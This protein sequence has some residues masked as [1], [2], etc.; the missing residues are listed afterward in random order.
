M[1]ISR[2]SNPKGEGLEKSHLREPPPPVGEN[3][4]G[5]AQKDPSRARE[6]GNGGI[7]LHGAEGE[8][9]A[10]GLRRK[11]GRK[12]KIKK[13][14]RISPNCRCLLMKEKCL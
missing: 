2:P 14:V 3:E 4:K 5:I 12:E 7:G 13:T 10:C 9:A 11:R 1:F 8:K 6:G